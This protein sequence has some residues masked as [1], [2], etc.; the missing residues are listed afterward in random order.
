MLSFDPIK[1]QRRAR[2]MGEVRWMSFYFR[3]FP[4]HYDKIV[5][6]FR[7]PQPSARAWFYKTRIYFK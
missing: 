1:T 2:R 7:P 4:L 5:R 3:H 6:K